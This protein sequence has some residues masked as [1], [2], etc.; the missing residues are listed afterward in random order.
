MGTLYHWEVVFATVFDPYFSQ[1]LYH[2]RRTHYNMTMD[3]GR[4]TKVREGH[5]D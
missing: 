1:F 2:G 5:M 4:I 3:V